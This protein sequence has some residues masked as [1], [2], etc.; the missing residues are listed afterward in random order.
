M[1][2]EKNHVCK[3]SML[4]SPLQRGPPL[5]QDNHWRRQAYLPL[6]LRCSCWNFFE[7]KILFNSVT[8]Y[9]RRYQGLFSLY[10][11]GTLRKYKNTS[12]L[13]SQIKLIQY[14]LYYLVEPDKYMYCEVWKGVYGLKKSARLA[15][16]NIVN[17]Q[18]PHSY[19]PIWEHPSLCKQQTHYRVFTLCIYNFCIKANSLYDAHHLLNAIRKYF[20]YS[21]DWEGQN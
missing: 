17:I 9:L 21:I 4:L 8:I 7:A 1:P 19:L 18:A 6:R 14:N 11:H 16:D 5:R 2:T 15:F 10:P 13:D 20:K 3:S 12:T